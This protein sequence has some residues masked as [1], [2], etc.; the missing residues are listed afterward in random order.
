MTE[1]YGHEFAP[2]AIDGDRRIVADESP[3]DGRVVK[4]LPEGTK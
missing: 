1:L 3:V 2:F 4:Q